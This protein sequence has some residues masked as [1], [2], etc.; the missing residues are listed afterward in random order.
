M[1]TRDESIFV[2]KYAGQNGG[3]SA[4]ALKCFLVDVARLTSKEQMYEN[5][6]SIADA[7]RA[8]G[9]DSRGCLRGMT[10][11]DAMDA[12]MKKF[13]ARAMIEAI[14]MLR[15]VEENDAAVEGESVSQSGHTTEQDPGES[16][17]AGEGISEAQDGADSSEEAD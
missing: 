17:G 11:Q 10:V 16:D 6:E 2:R 1:V 3:L 9:L 14:D 12:G 13:D 8:D 15:E 4:H 7:L 5:A